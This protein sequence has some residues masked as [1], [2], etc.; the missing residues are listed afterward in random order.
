M[1]DQE[2]KNIKTFSFIPE[3][4]KLLERYNNARLIHFDSQG[5]LNDKI[6]NFVVTDIMPRVGIIPAQVKNFTVDFEKKTVEV[7]LFDNVKN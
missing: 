6:N 7:E 5:A 2:K 3:E 4:L 1:V